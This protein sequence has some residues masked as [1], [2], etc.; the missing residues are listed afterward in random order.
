MTISRKALFCAALVLSFLAV[1]APA[2]A[3][4]GEA[5]FDRTAEIVKKEFYR[6]SELGSF[7]V[8]IA[9][10]R[11]QAGDLDDKTALDEGQRSLADRTEADHDDGPVDSGMKGPIGHFGSP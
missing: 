10:I 2:G 6:P 5:V 4:T 9:A 8:D 7:D 1:G 11:G 3:A